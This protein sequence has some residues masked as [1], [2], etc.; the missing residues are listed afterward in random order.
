MIKANITAI[1]VPLYFTSGP[2]KH[3]KKEKPRLQGLFI[4]WFD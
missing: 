3:L 2:L 1:G 4:G